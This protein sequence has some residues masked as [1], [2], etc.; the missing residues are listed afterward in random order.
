MFKILFAFAFDT[1]IIANTYF[2]NITNRSAFGSENSLILR[3]EES[4]SF[5][6]CNNLITY[7]VDKIPLVA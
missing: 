7:L 2:A 6:I 3:S 1:L 5:Y 4:M